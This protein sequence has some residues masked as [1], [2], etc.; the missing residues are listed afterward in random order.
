MLQ[1]K[2]IQSRARQSKAHCP[3]PKG[4]R[5]QQHGVQVR[6]SIPNH[7]RHPP[8]TPL[9]NK[10]SYEKFQ[11]EIHASNLYLVGNI[12]L[13]RHAG[14]YIFLV[15]LLRSRP[16]LK[17]FYVFGHHEFYKIS[18]QTAYQWMEK[19]IV[20]MKLEFGDRLVL[21]H[22]RRFDIGKKISVLG[23]TLW[24]NIL[25]EQRGPCEDGMT[26]FRPNNGIQNWDVNSHRAQHHKDLE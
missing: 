15:K 20:K 9:Q 4:S 14:L 24:S 18:F 13:V 5:D 12:V 16:D 19:F 3:S 23:C 22:R 1:N 17:I 10:Q 8:R 26:D 7:I 6:F 11:L 21:M 2:I 25:S